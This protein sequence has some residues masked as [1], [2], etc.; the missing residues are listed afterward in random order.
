M[1]WVPRSV[2]PGLQAGG[3]QEEIKVEGSQLQLYEEFAHE[4]VRT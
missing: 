1:F 3:V 2:S 4:Q